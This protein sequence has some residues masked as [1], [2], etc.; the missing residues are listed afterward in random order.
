MILELREAAW[1]Q[2]ALVPKLHQVQGLIDIAQRPNYLRFI[3]I[4][5]LGVR[6]CRLLFRRGIAH[7][8]DAVGD[9]PNSGNQKKRRDWEQ[10]LRFNDADDP[11]LERPHHAPAA[12]AA[13]ALI[14]PRYLASKI[15]RGSG[16]LNRYPCISSQSSTRSSRDCSWVSTPS[17]T[18]LSLSECARLMMV[19]TKARPSGLTVMSMMKERSIFKVC[20]GSRAKWLNDENPVP[21]SSMAMPTPSAR[22]ARR[23]A[24]LNLTSSM[25][26]LSVISNSSPD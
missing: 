12:P 16:L 20:T 13:A 17:A 8:G 22:I 11:K 6:R 18:T 24:M 23:L 15:S 14:A 19:D 2:S 4:E 3:G 26:T 9:C 7:T 10:S 21:K 1:A 5:Q 25:M